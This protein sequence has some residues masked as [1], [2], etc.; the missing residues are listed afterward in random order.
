MMNNINL[1]VVVTL[2]RIFFIMFCQNTLAENEIVLYEGTDKYSV[3]KYLTYLNDKNNSISINSILDGQLTNKFKHQN[4]ARNKVGNNTFWYYFSIHSKRETPSNWI[5]EIKPLNIDIID[6]YFISKQ[7]VEKSFHTGSTRPFKS[8]PIQNRHNLFPLHLE[9]EEAIKVFIRVH[10]AT[11]MSVPPPISIMERSLHQQSSQRSLVILSVGL[12][13]LL[14]MIIHNSFVYIIVRD[15]TYILYV[16]YTISILIAFLHINGIS[17]QYLW[18]Q[19]I[20]LHNSLILYISFSVNVSLI[21]FLSKL[22]TLKQRHL[23]IYRTLI[24]AIVIEIMFLP[25]HSIIPH[26]S[27]SILRN[28]YGT[29][30]ILYILSI[31]LWL[32][33]HGDR[34]A[35][36]FTLAWFTFCIGLILAIAAR[37]GLIHPNVISRHGFEIGAIIEVCLQSLVLA[38]RFSDLRSKTFHAHA[39]AAA[40]SSFLA[41]MSHE[42]RTP[43]NAIIGFTELAKKQKGETSLYLK[44]IKN[45]SKNLLDIINDIFNMSE[46]ENGSRILRKVSFDIYDLINDQVDFFS[47]TIMDKSIEVIFIIENNVPPAL[48]GDSHRLS[49]ILINLVNN[50]IKYTQEG[51]VVIRVKLIK[52]IDNS[53][54]LEFSITDT[55]IGLSEK[56]IKNLFNPFAQ[57]EVDANHHAEGS[58]LGLSICKDLV[59]LLGGEINISSKLGKGSVFKFTLNF[60]LQSIN[61]EQLLAHKLS[62]PSELR[63]IRIL[64]IDQNR[65]SRHFFEQ[66]LRSMGLN[67]CDA[68]LFS[69]INEALV[70]IHIGPKSEPYD[71]A[72][73]DGKQIEKYGVKSLNRLKFLLNS[74]PMEIAIISTLGHSAIN[75]CAKK[76]SISIFIPKPISLLAL[77]ESIICI[78]KDTEKTPISSSD[79]L[80]TSK[81][82]KGIKVLLVEDN[83]L[84]QDFA[85]ALLSK[86]G[87]QTTLAVNGQQAVDCVL[88]EQFDIVLMDIQMPVMDGL[89]A[90]KIIRKDPQFKS[91]PIIAVTAAVLSQDQ[92]KYFSAGMND[93]V[94]KPIDVKS[95]FETLEKWLAASSPEYKFLPYNIYSPANDTDC[96]IHTISQQTHHESSSHLPDQLAGINILNG[97]KR[98]QG[99]EKLFIKILNGFRTDNTSLSDDIQSAL[100]KSDVPLAKRL[101]HTTRGVAG[102]LGANKLAVASHMFETALTTNDSDI[103]QLQNHFEVALKEVLSSA[104]IIVT[105]F[106]QNAKD[107]SSQ[108]PPPITQADEILDIKRVT[109]V[110]LTLRQELKN[111]SFSATHSTKV[112]VSLLKNHYSDNDLDELV[113]AIDTLNYPKALPLL[114]KIADK[115]GVDIFDN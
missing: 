66:T 36:N 73:I 60:A 77:K 91:L 70:S 33:A 42:I 15:S 74:H 65:S 54:N 12:G 95:F 108:A 63:N 30:F 81:T 13:M 39:S 52:R 46:I 45:A 56:Q 103:D 84:N 102:T 22:L 112:L 92:E 89:E 59:N 57:A 61:Q 83:K 16:C 20:W 114:I 10:E 29:A 87:V 72:L 49:Q 17:Y 107:N 109:Q 1:F 58:G 2:A 68:D 104:E 6:I 21:L 115:I 43:M 100:I 4:R 27:F 8:R 111:N 64:I 86:E 48:I 97:I 88:Q 5:I 24:I 69:N 11:T 34:V 110:A 76:A 101:L 28:L 85:L 55:G 35:R 75:Q 14:V 32:W 67:I 31:G 105:I 50:A 26:G 38:D 79:K 113:N 18:P 62:L 3:N 78:F 51:E 94:K 40:K 23:A 71:L 41:N 19:N 37:L 96:E 53:V 7:G 93:V 99:D 80:L 98:M 9:R 44:K 82:L 106:E 47:S 25:L 90:T